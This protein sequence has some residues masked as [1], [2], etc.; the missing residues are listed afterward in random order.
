MRLLSLFALLGVGSF[1]AAASGQRV[2]FAVRGVVF[3]SIRGRPLQNASVTIGGRPEPTTTNSR[4]QFKFDDVPAGLYTLTAHHAMLDSIGLSGLAVRASIGK[5]TGEIRLALPSFATLWQVTCPGR[6][7]RDSGIVF[8]TIQ[9]ADGGGPVA[10]AAVELSWTDLGVDKRRRVIARR[11]HLRTSSNDRGEY[12]VC[13]VPPEMPF[14]LFANKANRTSDSIT[15]ATA[16]SRIR[17]RDLFIGSKDVADSSRRGT[18]VGHVTDPSGESM[19]NV[20]ILIDSTAGVRTDAAG[21]FVISRVAPG[22]RQLRLFA[23]GLVP[24][25]VSADVL[26]K[27][28]V[29]VSIEVRKLVQLAGMRTKAVSGVRVFATEFNERRRLG[30]G[31]LRDSVEI[32]KHPDFVSFLREFP[33]LQVRLGGT[34]VAFAVPDVQG[35]T[36][37]PD[38]L[39]DGAKAGPGHLI[40]LHS[41]EVGAIEFYPRAAHIPARFVPPAFT[42]QCGMILVWTKYGLSNR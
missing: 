14:Q 4:G 37:A 27:D 23:I 42:P 21:H 18:I 22:T 1:S 3:D 41:N 38:I 33:G 10:N 8:G 36:C 30:F 39:I 13:G 6:P 12:A 2:G 31:Y 16:L 9:S 19:E 35:G 17:R 20:Q 11:W 7:P 29:V 15:I 40:D 34:S 24:T 28:T 32:A 5:S 25:Y 26:P